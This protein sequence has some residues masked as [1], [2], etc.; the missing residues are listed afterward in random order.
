MSLVVDFAGD[1]DRAERLAAKKVAAD[2]DQMFSGQLRIAYRVAARFAGRLMFVP[3]IGWHCWDGQRWA[4]DQ[5]RA[6]E[7][8]VDTV[9]GDAMRDGARDPEMRADVRKCGSSAGRAGVLTI[10]GSLHPLVVAASDLDVDAHLVN[11]SN[12][13]LDLSTLEL[14]PH[15]PNDKLTKVTRA[16][17]R[18][19]ATGGRW[20]SFLSEVLPDPDVRGFV[21]RLIGV[22]L[23]GAVREHV[24]PIWTGTGANGKSVAYAAILHALGDYACPAEPDLFMAREGAHPTGSMDLRGR[25]LVVVSESDQHRRLAEGT[26][27]RLTGGDPIKSRYMGKDF[28]TFIPSHL[29]LLVTNHL[30]K[31]S[32]DDEAVWRRLRVIPFEVV[33]PPEQRDSHLGEYLAADADA[34]LLWAVK[35]WQAYVARGHKLDEP[36]SVLVATGLYRAESD[37][38]ARFLAER[39]YL[40]AQVKVPAGD[41][42]AAWEAWAKV[43]G[44]ELLSPKPFGQ[45][46]ERH[47]LPLCRVSHGTRYRPGVTLLPDDDTDPNG[48]RY[49]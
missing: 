39:C 38:V 5:T 46:L 16:A 12:G 20:E 34:V 24:L 13:A 21:Q 30:P 11:V 36:E 3:Q 31:V 42:Y 33:I 6:A 17:Y 29:A 23:L 15:D 8:A 27:K 40:N 10:A 32:G 9:L 45:A 43:D 35:G 22:S 28:V 14:R 2:A 47:G 1:P 44:A 48:G 37:A 4:P 41:L 26:M 49:R 18:P 19:E 7:R 25:R